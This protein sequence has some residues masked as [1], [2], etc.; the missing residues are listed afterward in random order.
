MIYVIINKW[1]KFNACKVYNEVDVSDLN[2]FVAC[3]SLFG[4][5]V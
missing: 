4:A 3:C 5:V 1:L 2:C